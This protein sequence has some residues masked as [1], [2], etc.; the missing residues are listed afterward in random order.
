MKN[1]NQK[2]LEQTL[3]RRFFFLSFLKTLVVGSISWRFFDLQIIENQKYKKLSNQ[4]QFNYFVI[5][6]ERGR[7]LDRKMRLLAGNMD[8]FSLVLNWNESVNV[9]ALIYKISQIIYIDKKDLNRYYSSLSEKKN[10]NPKEI[11]IT[12]NLSQKDFAK[13]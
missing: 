4:N 5:P 1:N 7:I 9:K 8:S 13:L 6:P 2:I 12:K 11:L 10:N 3:T